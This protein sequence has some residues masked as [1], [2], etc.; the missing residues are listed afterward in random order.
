VGLAT[1]AE[2][3]P[4]AALLHREVH[5]ASGLLVLPGG[6][7]VHTHRDWDFG[8]A[9]T[10][11]TFGTGTT[12]AAFG[13]TTTIVDF[14]NQDGDAGAE[15]RRGGQ[16]STCSGRLMQS[17]PLAWCK[18]G[19]GIALSGGI[20]RIGQTA[21]AGAIV[22]LVGAILLEQNVFVAEDADDLGAPFD[23]A[24]EALDRIG[25][26]YEDRCRCSAT[27]EPPVAYGVTIR[28]RGTGSTQVQA[29]RSI[30]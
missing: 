24:V 5:D 9:R 30:R 28:D 29:G 18:S 15:G 20:G 21:A 10:A 14:A 22:R 23:L 16:N 17:C 26:W 8:V 12:A 11:D 3:A 2:V 25:N 19:G 1:G 13:G 4:Q 7:D 6:V 27:A